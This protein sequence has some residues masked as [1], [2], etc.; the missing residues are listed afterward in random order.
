MYDCGRCRVKCLDGLSWIKNKKS[1]SQISN[2][3]KLVPNSIILFP[4][5][6]P[7]PAEPRCSFTCPASRGHIGTR[8]TP[9]YHLN[10]LNPIYLSILRNQLPVRARPFYRSRLKPSSTYKG[11]LLLPR[12]HL[13]TLKQGH[14]PR[15]IGS[16]N[17]TYQDT[18]QNFI[19]RRARA[20]LIE[21]LVGSERKDI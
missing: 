6:I 9:F 3:W 13:A 1:E 21:H 18:H 7:I 2:S 5:W 12:L 14:R 8:T 19:P 15:P 10:T 16:H 20:A 17:P 11:P 4:Q